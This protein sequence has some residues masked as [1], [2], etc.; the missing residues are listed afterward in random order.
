MYKINNDCD[1]YGN[2]ESIDGNNNQRYILALAI[3]LF[4]IKV[5]R[6]PSNFYTFNDKFYYFEHRKLSKYNIFLQQQ[7]GKKHTRN[8]I[9]Y[10]I[11]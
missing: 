1:N 10:C 6:K 2:R 9:Q 4:I 11:R 8:I 3:T 7:C 5:G